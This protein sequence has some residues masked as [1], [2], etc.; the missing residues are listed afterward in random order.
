MIRRNTWLLLIILA[1]LVG[2]GYYLK[3]QKAKTIAEATPTSGPEL[4]FNSNDGTPSDIKI[5]DL[6]GNSVDIAR[7]SSGI[8]ALKAPTAAAADQGSSEAAATQ[9]SSLRILSNVQ[10]GPDTVGLDKPSYIITILF[11]GDK[12]HKLT[13]GSVTP[14]QDGYYVQLDT[15]KIQIVDKQGLDAILGLLRTPPFAVT[16]TPIVTATSTTQPDTPT[17]QTTPT[18]PSTSAPVTPTKSP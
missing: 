8:W 4:L 11:S 13:V 9:I 16:P 5:D 14:I 15:G 2:F 18:S 3:N 12:S 17:P 1:A 6:T 10:L 7:D